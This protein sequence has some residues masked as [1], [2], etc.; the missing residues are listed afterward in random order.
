M[1]S[2]FNVYTEQHK[3][4]YIQTCHNI[5]YYIIMFYNTYI[6]PVYPVT[7]TTEVKGPKTV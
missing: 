7:M 3:Y 6:N 4:I 5:T 1:E 2:N